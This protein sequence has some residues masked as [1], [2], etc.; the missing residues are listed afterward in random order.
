[1]NMMLEMLFGEALWRI[2]S[3]LVVAML[4]LYGVQVGNGFFIKGHL[5]L[6]LRGKR[7]N[8]IIGDNVS[9]FGELD[10][11]NRE[12]GTIILCD[13][14]VVD[15]PCRLVAAR[16]AVVEIGEGSALTPYLLLNAGADV[17]IGKGTIIGPR[18]SIN[19]SE[20]VFQR[21]TPVRQSGYEHKAITIG[22]DCWLAA[23]VSVVKGVTIADGSVVGAN[24]VVTKD[25]V[26]YS[27]N[28][29]VPARQIGERR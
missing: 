10:L 8:I 28:A 1:M 14:V 13:S 22:N 12:N 23:N 29:G 27:V 17:R 26:P 9:V 15:G 3:K 21:N 2:W 18:A 19:A 25:T 20:H 11:R 5:L 24:A 6:K 16:E 4:R 7:K